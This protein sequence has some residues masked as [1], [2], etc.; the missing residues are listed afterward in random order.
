MADS[1][2]YHRWPMY[3]ITTKPGCIAVD[4]GTTIVTVDLQRRMDR[5]IVRLD[6]PNEERGALEH[7]DCPV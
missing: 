7:V 4:Y 6:Y 2:W 5:K 3:L 1:A